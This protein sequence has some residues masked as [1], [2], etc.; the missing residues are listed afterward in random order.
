[1]GGGGW[2]WGGKGWEG[3]GPRKFYCPQNLHPDS[4][5]ERPESTC[6]FGTLCFWAFPR[7]PEPQ[8]CLSI[9]TPRIQ[10]SL[11]HYNDSLLVGLPSHIQLTPNPKFACR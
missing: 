9:A 2:I 1:M 4:D 8:L 6:R 7:H 10:V 3:G 11:L 5:I